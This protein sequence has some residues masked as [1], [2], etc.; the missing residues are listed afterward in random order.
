MTYLSIEVIRKYL[1]LLETIGKH[2][3]NM[4]ILLTTQAAAAACLVYTIRTFCT[5]FPMVSSS[6]KYLRITS[7]DK[8]VLL[9]DY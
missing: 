8:Q 4:P 6:F 1:K 7:M 3:Q 9:Y 2:M 5:C